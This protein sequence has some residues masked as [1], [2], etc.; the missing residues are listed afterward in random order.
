MSHVT[1]VETDVSDLEFIA[2]NMREKDRR[3]VVDATGVT[4]VLIPL[5]KGY[6][7]S[8]QAWTVVVDDTVAGAV[9]VAPIPGGSKGSPWFLGTDYMTPRA[10]A[11]MGQETLPEMHK[12]YPVLWNLIPEYQT[13]SIR[14]L[15]KLGFT[16]YK[17][18]PLRINGVPFFPFMRIDNVPDR[19]PV[20]TKMV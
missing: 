6:E 9:G 18:T 20:T 4:D 1:L 14:W 17:E 10:F 19:I 13:T 2:D 7:V 3:E 15:T 5:L 12:E 8:T 16:V 11:K